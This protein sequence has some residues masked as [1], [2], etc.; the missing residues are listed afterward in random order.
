ME[1]RGEHVTEAT[2]SGD[3]LQANGI[4]PV[5]VMTHRV[6]RATGRACAFGAATALVVGLP[7]LAGPALADTPADWPT[8]PAVSGLDWLTVLLLIPAGA[9]IVIALLVTLPSLVKGDRHDPSK[10]W[11]GTQEWFGGPA[12][13][14]HAARDGGDDTGG[15]SARF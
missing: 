11:A 13:G 3:R 4:Y 5:C 12:K 9:A 1:C 15:A 10:A 2:R 14:A 8:P 7:L 6:A